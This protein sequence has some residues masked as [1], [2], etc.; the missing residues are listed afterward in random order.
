MQISDSYGNDKMKVIAS[1]TLQKKLSDDTH[2]AESLMVVVEHVLDPS[3]A[4]C[5]SSW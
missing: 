1:N 3:I 4:S 2:H 5:R